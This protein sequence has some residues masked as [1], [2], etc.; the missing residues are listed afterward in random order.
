MKRK[1]FIEKVNSVKDWSVAELK[2]HYCKKPKDCISVTS[3]DIAYRIFLKM[4][5]DSLI[6]IQEQF[7]ALFLNAQLEALGFRVISTG[8]LNSTTIDYQFLFSCALVCRA[9][10]II[11]AHNHP[12]ESPE[13]SNSDKVVTEQIRIIGEKLDINIDD[14]LIITKKGYYSFIDSSFHNDRKSNIECTR[15][16]NEIR[17]LRTEVRLYMT[18]YTESLETI[19][20]LRKELLFKVGEGPR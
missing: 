7:C 15:S 17:K 16:C 4:W 1:V 8:K 2:V 18:E 6:N 19:V 20:K 5:D 14:H 3:P 10:S 9:S 12:S 11:V 13:P